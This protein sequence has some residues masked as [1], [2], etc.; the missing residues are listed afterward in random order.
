MMYAPVAK[1]DNART[2]GIDGFLFTVIAGIVEPALIEEVSGAVRTRGPC[3]GGD[4]V[5]HKANVLF[6]PSLLGGMLC[7]AH[8]VIIG[9]HSHASRQSERMRVLC[10]HDGR[11]MT[12]L[13]RLVQTRLRVVRALQVRRGC[14]SLQWLA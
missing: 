4:R 12:Q 1:P 9:R 3:D 13:S 14:Q 2:T 5:N 7:G 8:R 11:L 6:L 10:Q